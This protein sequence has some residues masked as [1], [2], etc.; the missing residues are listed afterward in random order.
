MVPPA[1]GLR[2]QAS[3]PAKWPGWTLVGVGGA[4]AVT[5]IVL[6]AL[7][8]S[9]LSQF[10]TDLAV[11]NQA[12]L[13]SGLTHEEAATRASSINARIGVAAGLT[14]AGLAAAGVG[15]WL[16]VRTPVRDVT[17]APQMGGATLVWRF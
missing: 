14:G 17:V 9:D 1:G 12:G 7:A 16:L 2:A 15:A 13:I 8:S 3:E 4:V 5:G 6:Y 10:K 11:T